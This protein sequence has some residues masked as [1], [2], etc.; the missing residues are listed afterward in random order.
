MDTVYDL[1]IIGSG[2]AGL[3]A[4][5]YASRY[6]LKHVV[7]GKMVGG[8]A[9]EAHKVCNFP[10]EKEIG[11]FELVAKEKK[12]TV[13]IIRARSAGQRKM[14]ADPTSPQ[15]RSYSRLY[16]VTTKEVYPSRICS[17]NV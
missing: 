17:K 4:S 15:R 16:S 12:K 1:L 9:S 7:I 2:P 11:G 10:S 3:T 14:V 13:T 5:I 6:K 8:L